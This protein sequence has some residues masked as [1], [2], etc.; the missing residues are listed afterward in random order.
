MT[1]EPSRGRR[2]GRPSTSSRQRRTRRDVRLRL[3]RNAAARDQGDELLAARRHQQGRVDLELERVDAPRP[4][5]AEG[6]HDVAAGVAGDVLVDLEAVARED[7]GHRGHDLRGAGGVVARADDHLVVLHPPRAAGVA[8][9][10]QGVA[11]RPVQL[12]QELLEG[13]VVGVVERAQARLEVG[14][15]ERPR[16]DGHVA[17]GVGAHHPAA[18]AHL[19]LVVLEVVAPAIDVHE[20]ARE[21]GGQHGGPVL[22]QV[23]VD[24]AHEGVGEAVGEG[25]EPGLGVVVAGD[26]RA[27]AA[28]RSG[29]RSPGSA[30]AGRPPDA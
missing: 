16:E 10:Q 29:A 22:V 20:H 18:G 7:A 13:R 15:P 28:C 24:V 8:V 26:V 30:C 14:E 9:Q 17:H 11:V 5:L 6:G 23:A 2:G 25:L 19:A 21:R 12:G 4:G 3:L 1:R 27:A